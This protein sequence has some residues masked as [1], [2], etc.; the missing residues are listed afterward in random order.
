MTCQVAEWLPEAWNIKVAQGTSD[1]PTFFPPEKDF[2]HPSGSRH[3]KGCCQGR[4]S[5]YPKGYRCKLTNPL[6]GQ[7]KRSNTMTT[8]KDLASQALLASNA[9]NLSGVVHSFSRAMTALRELCPG[10][11]TNFYNSHPVSVIYSQAISNITDSDS[12]VA[13][14]RAVD[15]CEALAKGE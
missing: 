3:H 1:Y 7:Y 13:Y 10:E 6:G 12:L 2:S 4:A 8:I 9:C 11:D 14:S 15:A 5:Q